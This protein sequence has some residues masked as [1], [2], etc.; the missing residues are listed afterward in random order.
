MND[1]AKKPRDGMVELREGYQPTHGTLGNPPK[2]SI[3][4]KPPPKAP[5]QTPNKA[6]SGQ[7]SNKS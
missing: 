3:S 4:I 2:G 5:E 6:P 1:R 7:Q